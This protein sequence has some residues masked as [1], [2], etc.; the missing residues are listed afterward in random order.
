MIT[1]TINPALMSTASEYFWSDIFNVIQKSYRVQCQPSAYGVLFTGTLSQI[2]N[3]GKILEYH[4]KKHLPNMDHPNIF[5]QN[6]TNLNQCDMNF[7]QQG[8]AVNHA[9]MNV[10]QSNLQSNQNFDRSDMSLKQSATS[11]NQSDTNFHQ[12]DTAVSYAS[13]NVNQSGLQFNESFYQSDMPLNQSGTLF[14]ESAL[15]FTQHPINIP[16]VFITMA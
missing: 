10:N 9:G 14:N 2:I 5:N 8:T 11:F 16:K 12:M 6:G 3:A 7:Y 15:S 1:A 4:R 13:T